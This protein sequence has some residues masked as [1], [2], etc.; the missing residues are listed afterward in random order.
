MF[1]NTLSSLSN[2]ALAQDF[3]LGAFKFFLILSALIYMVFAFVILRQVKVMKST[4]ITPF[5][6]V[7][8]TLGI[9]HLALAGGV[10]VLFAGVL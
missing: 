10:L 1:F 8:R 6:P 3:L 2:P 4:L 5:S 7:I 9:L